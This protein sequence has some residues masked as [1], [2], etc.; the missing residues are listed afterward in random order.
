MRK[1]TAIE[2][3]KKNRQRVNIFL[4]GEF[5]FG[6]SQLVA[7]WLKVGQEL[8]EEKIASLQAEDAREVALQKALNFLSYRAR[9]QEEIRQNLR[10]HAIPEAVIEE[11]LERLQN[12]GLAN[13]QQFAQAWVENRSTFRPRSRRVLSME[14]RQ[15]GLGDE[16][17][18][19]VLQD[20]VDEKTLAYQAA[21]R[22]ARRLEG[23][24]W[25]DF[26]RKLSEFLARR[27]FGYE[28]IGEAV[29][30]IWREQARNENLSRSDDPNRSEQLIYDDEENP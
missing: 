22:K 19:T 17:I 15:K 11:I 21:V 7:A 10:K 12:V 25:P 30:Q 3:Q 23:L 1:I 2:V 8:S 6:L 13:D 9:S 28:V 29:R 26:R 27:G 4:D 20:A 24:E 16:V 14:L 18:Q 5:A